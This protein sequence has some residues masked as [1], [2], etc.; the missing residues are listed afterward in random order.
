MKSQATR[1]DV[2]EA[3]R[4][5]MQTRRELVALTPCALAAAYLIASAFVELFTA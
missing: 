1:L 3:Q 4:Q 5:R 2:I